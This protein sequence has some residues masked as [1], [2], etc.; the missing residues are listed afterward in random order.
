[1]YRT[2]II[3]SV[4]DLTNKALSLAPNAPELYGADKK[5]NWENSTWINPLASLNQKYKAKTNTLIANAVLSYK[6]IENVDG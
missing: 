2:V 6:L 3:F 4:A 5:L 1:M